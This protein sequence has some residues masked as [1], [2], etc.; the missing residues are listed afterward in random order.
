MSPD[1]SRWR[2]IQSQR[3]AAEL[4]WA[5]RAPFFRDRLRSA[6]RE[7]DPLLR[8]AN[9]KPFRKQ[10]AIVASRDMCIAGAGI[11]R[12]YLTSGTTGRG[13][14]RLA[15]SDVDDITFVFGHL[16]HYK[17]ARLRGG[18]GIALTWPASCQAGGVV[19]RQAAELLGLRALEI[20]SYDT[21]GKLDILRKFRPRA[22]VGSALYLRRLLEASSGEQLSIDACFIAGEAYPTS[23]IDFMKLRGIKPFEWYG[24]TMLGPVAVSCEAGLVTQT[25]RGALHVAPHMFLIEVLDDAGRQVLPGERGEL[26]VTALS[27]V[28][29]PTIRY[30][31]GDVVRWLGWTECSCGRTWPSIE[32]GTIARIDDM[33]RI[34]GT[35]VWPAAIDAVVFALPDVQDYRGRLWVDKE[36]RERATL[37]VQTSTLP[38][39]CPAIAQRMQ[40]DLKERTGCSFEVAITT[41]QQ[42]L[43]AFKPR[44]WTDAR[45]SG[46]THGHKS[47]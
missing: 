36:G 42:E 37:S 43:K 18:D 46:V 27:R 25:G 17:I 14:E 1:V 44:R 24:T 2:S 8:L 9:V 16:L 33:M 20:G 13:Q 32:A 29:Q 45:F 26:V 31:T 40:R 30:A 38:G 15:L 5:E 3:L 47:S 28:T 23:W 39:D 21:S 41:E 10:D 35:N 7:D 6:Q 19:L 22:I 11:A 12:E 34:R 4:R